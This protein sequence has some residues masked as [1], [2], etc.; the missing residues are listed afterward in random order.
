[1]QPALKKVAPMI[2][3]L[4]D[5]GRL[6]SP[7]TFVEPLSRFAGAIKN[8]LNAQVTAMAP[9]GFI[10]KHRPLDRRGARR[11]SAH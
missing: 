8:Q 5:K 3:D 1:M 11:Q 4:F 9:C 7:M 6:Y 2:M 10:S